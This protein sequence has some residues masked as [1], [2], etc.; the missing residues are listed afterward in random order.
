MSITTITITILYYFRKEMEI[1]QCLLDVNNFLDGTETE[2][3]TTM[4]WKPFEMIDVTKVLKAV[5]LDIAGVSMTIMDIR[6]VAESHVDVS[7]DPVVK[8]GLSFAQGH[9]ER[10]AKEYYRRNGSTTLM[11]PW[12]S[13]VEGM[14]Y[15]R[16][17]IDNSD[18]DDN[19]DD[20]VG[21]KIEKRMEESQ[22]RWK[23]MVLKEIN[24]FE[25]EDEVPAI[26]PKRTARWS[27]EEDEEL[28][29]MVKQLGAF[30]WRVILKSSSLLRRRYKRTAGMLMYISPFPLLLHF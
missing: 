12:S 8:R 15:G 9:T 29:R 21:E 28:L 10:T 17:T 24:E 19:N 25:V 27:K 22:K 18:D 13:H 16:N 7:S 14:I 23:K 4:S 6:T 2:E 30:N 5:T 3:S 20:E 26:N 11:D 1:F